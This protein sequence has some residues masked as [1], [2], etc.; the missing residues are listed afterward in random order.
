[1]KPTWIT[2]N[3]RQHLDELPSGERESTAQALEAIFSSDSNPSGNG[4]E[5][6]ALKSALFAGSLAIWRKQMESRPTVLVFDDL[7]WADSAS[8]EL[9][10]HLLQLTD[11]G[12]ILFLCAFRPDRGAP[13]LEGQTSGRN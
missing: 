2:P 9:L 6:E 12:P 7:H 13:S 1:M 5:G 11:S 8:T 10:T 4:L 3:L